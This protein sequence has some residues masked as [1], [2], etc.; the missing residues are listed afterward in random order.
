MDGAGRLGARRP[1]GPV[2]PRDGPFPDGEKKKKQKAEGFGDSGE[3]EEFAFSGG[4]IWAGTGCARIVCR[5]P[6]Q[7]TEKQGEREVSKRK[8]K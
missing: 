8:R 4:L 6:G 3:D 2:D 1:F 7:N 5:G